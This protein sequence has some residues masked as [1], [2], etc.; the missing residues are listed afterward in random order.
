MRA[1]RRVSKKGR[2]LGAAERG[3]IVQRIIVDHWTAA[4]AAAA[5][6]LDE[7][8]V[9]LWVEDY[10]R[11]GMAS[12]RESRSERSSLLSLAARAGRRLLARLRRGSER[13]PS[14]PI[15]VPPSHFKRPSERRNS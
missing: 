10:R 14:P 5:F 6:D 2:P 11:R 8:L 3:W 7:R 9:A 15:E 4:E 13:A 1:R 12:L